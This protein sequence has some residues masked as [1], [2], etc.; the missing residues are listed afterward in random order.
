MSNLTQTPHI[1][2][3]PERAQ[4]PSRVEVPAEEEEAGAAWREQEREEELRYR[5]RDDPFCACTPDKMRFP[6]PVG[7]LD[8][9]DGLTRYGE[10]LEHVWNTDPGAD[11]EA[12]SR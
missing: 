5:Y 1:G 12:G 9:G 4:A 11:R 7:I 6:K 2:P 3:K 8:D 10:R